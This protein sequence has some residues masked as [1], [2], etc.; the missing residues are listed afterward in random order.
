MRHAAKFS[1][2]SNAV[3]GHILMRGERFQYKQKRCCKVIRGPCGP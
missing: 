1:V 3:D 2:M